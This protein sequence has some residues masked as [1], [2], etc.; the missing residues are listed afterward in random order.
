MP[1]ISIVTSC[2]NEEENVADLYQQIWSAMETLPN[3][4][5][6]LIFIDNASAD[7]TI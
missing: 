6:E 4:T 7:C 3:Y 1:F 5:Y 2:Y